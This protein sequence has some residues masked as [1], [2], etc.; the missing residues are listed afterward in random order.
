MVHLLLRWRILLL[1]L[2]TILH[3]RLLLCAGISA[4]GLR[5]AVLRIIAHRIR[6][7]VMRLAVVLMLRLLMLLVIVA[8]LRPCMTALEI[9]VDPAFVIMGVVL[10]ALLP[11]DLL[12]LWLDLLDVIW[13]VVAFTHDHVKMSLACRLRVLDP[14]FDNLL[15]LFYKLAVKINRVACDFADC[16]ILTE[17]VL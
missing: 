12:H 8:V 4:C 1:L 2:P 9:H 13:A 7:L 16:I 14:L 6:R 3:L 15:G 5:I 11:T 10:Q 17:D